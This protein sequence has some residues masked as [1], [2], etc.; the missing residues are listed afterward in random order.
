MNSVRGFDW[1]E[2]SARD[3]NGDEI[4]GEKY[5]QANIEYQIPVF[6]ESGIVALV[7]F[8]AGNV[9]GK[10]DNVDL[11]DTRES[12]GGGIRWYSP[13]GPIRLEYGVRLDPL[14]GEESGG[15]FEF[16]MGSAF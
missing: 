16:S 9:Y 1:Q 11:S 4:G 7:F 12:A 10:D 13:V 14:P 15:Q 3:E 5:V 6:K 2:I 8:D